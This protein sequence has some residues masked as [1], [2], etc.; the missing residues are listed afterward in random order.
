M[1]RRREEKEQSD[2]RPEQQR[3][4][5]LGAGWKRRVSGPGPHLRVRNLHFHKGLGGPMC[6]SQGKRYH[7]TVQ[8]LGGR[9][10]STPGRAA[11]EKSVRPEPRRAHLHGEVVTAPPPQ[12]VRASQLLAQ[13]LAQSTD[14]EHRGDAAQGR[15]LAHHLLTAGLSGQPQEAASQKSPC[16][17]L[18][19]KRAQNRAGTARK[20]GGRGAGQRGAWEW[21][22]SHEQKE[23]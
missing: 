10:A 1:Q 16:K 17:P 11:T 6:T 13:C 12:V 8:K 3:R 22:C 9:A 7:W 2:P 20:A 19:R 5:L 4:H 23:Q 18:W 14:Q 21:L 15:L